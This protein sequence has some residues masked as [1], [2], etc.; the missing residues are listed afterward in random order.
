MGLFIFMLL[1]TRGQLNEEAAFTPAG[2]TGPSSPLLRRFRQLV[3]FLGA[4][5]YQRY[6]C[7]FKARVQRPRGLAS[8]V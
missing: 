5:C 6:T 4:N 8:F 7:I 1:I 3:V 2:D